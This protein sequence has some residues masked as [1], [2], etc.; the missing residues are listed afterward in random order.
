MK[1]YFIVNPGARTGNGKGLWDELESRLEASKTEYETFFTKKEENAA[2]IAKLICD[3]HPENKRIVV[4]GGD[5]TV[6]E[7]INGLYDYGRIL[8]GIVP[9]GSGNDLA[10]GLGIPNDHEKAL[11]HVLHPS[12]FKPVDHGFLE[13]L[14]DDTPAR[15]FA[16]S[17]GIGYDAD[18]CYHVQK[19]PLKKIFNKLGIGSS[20]YFLMGLK[21]IFAN[22]RA[23]MTITV[24]GKRKMTFDKVV[25]VSSMNTLYEGGGYP[26][27][28]GADPS[29]GKLSLCIVEGISRL[30]HCFL[31]TK[32]GKAEHV[33]SK[34][35]HIL[36]CKSV[37][38]E[39]DRP[40]VIHTDGEVAGMHSH[41][42]LSCLPEQ[43]RMML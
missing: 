1:Y 22:K 2:D 35:I 11:A 39:A 26:M 42:R 34:G 25:F 15:K 10:R 28:P 27:A 21:L 37:E 9:A 36:N 12:Q 30:K 16:V 4:V 6:N 13:Y 20:I 24:D 8:F 23:K 43:I 14:D 41:I 38:I 19:S 7:V 29:D 18:I 17:S 40:L 32:I 3:E 31:M 5:G 33:K